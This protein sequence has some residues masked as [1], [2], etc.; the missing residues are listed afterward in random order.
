MPITHVRR[1]FTGAGDDNFV[2]S[3]TLII[4]PF[5]M[6]K[7]IF[8]SMVLLCLFG[9]V[10]ANDVKNPVSKQ[11]KLV[12]SFD[13]LIVQGDLEVILV[14]DPSSVITVDGSAADIAGITIQTRNNRLVISESRAHKEGKVVIRIP[15]Q[16]LKAVDIHGNASLRSAGILDVKTLNVFL[17]GDCNISLEV[18]GAVSVTHSGECAIEYYNNKRIPVKA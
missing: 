2:L 18:A 15:V 6:K 14:T 4:K 17:N 7:S 16:Q 8:S 3:F 10:V 13:K 1:L 11:V 12:S 5:F 9:S